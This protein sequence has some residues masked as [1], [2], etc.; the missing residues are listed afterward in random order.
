MCP[1][2]RSGRRPSGGNCWPPRP[3]GRRRP[4][5][6]WAWTEGPPWSS[7]GG[8]G[9]RERRRHEK[10]SFCVMPVVGAVVEADAVGGRRAAFGGG[11]GIR[12]V[13]VPVGRDGG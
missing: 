6:G 3:G 9:T 7:S 10:A 5:G 4:C 11:G 1:P 13:L 2:R 12:L 8:W